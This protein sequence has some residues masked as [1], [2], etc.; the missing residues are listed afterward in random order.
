MIV[1]GSMLQHSWLSYAGNDPR[2]HQLHKTLFPKW[3]DGRVKPGHDDFWRLA[4]LF[5]FCY[6]ARLI[7]IPFA[8]NP[9]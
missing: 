5:T 7:V 1:L 4:S 6:G 8:L 3:M 2:I 9:M